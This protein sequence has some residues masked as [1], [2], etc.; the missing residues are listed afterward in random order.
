M[1]NFISLKLLDDMI[2]IQMNKVRVEYNKPIYIGFTVL[3]LSKWKM[4]NFHYDYMK[5]KYKVNINLSYMDTDS[6]IYDIETNDLYDDIRD[7]INCHFDT[8]AYPKQNI[9]NIPL[10]N[11]KVLG[12]MKG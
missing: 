6:F 12:M 5:P 11:K 2:A 3:E 7:D 9:F 8:S 10:L 4:Y 1:V